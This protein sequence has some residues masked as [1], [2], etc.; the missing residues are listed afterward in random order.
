M[1]DFIATACTGCG[2]KVRAPISASGRT[3]PCPRCRT[4]VHVPAL[5]HVAKATSATSPSSLP[6]AG[7]TP[8][9]KDTSSPRSGKHA[10]QPVR[11]ALRNHPRLVMSVA[12][13]VSGAILFGVAQS[14]RPR[15]AR[16]LPLTAS[17]LGPA[18][19]P[20]QPFEGLVG[21]VRKGLSALGAEVLPPFTEHWSDAK[22]ANDMT[23]SSTLKIELAQTNPWEVR[24][25][26]R[27]GVPYTAAIRFQGNAPGRIVGTMRVLRPPQPT[28]G[29]FTPRASVPYSL[30]IGIR[31]SG[32]VE[33]EYRDD[34]WH[35][36]SDTIVY[37][38]VK[39]EADPG[40]NDFVVL[41]I[42]T[43]LH[44]EMSRLNGR[45]RRLEEIGAKQTFRVFRDAAD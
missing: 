26:W 25:P 36:T 10:T 15:P 23:I 35:L 42:A 32:D 17:A 39:V 2:A 1:T 18:K 7:K 6:E 41:E 28:Y 38:Y 16:Y 30:Q 19:E 43:G 27:D 29:L 24:K 22:Y 5:P 34:R 45:R 12:T 3:A 21:N 40:T 9:V 4:P 13:A 33:Y 20:R 37:D 14:D 8:A 44:I 11:T 31:V